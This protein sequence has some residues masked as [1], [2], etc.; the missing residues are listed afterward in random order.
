MATSDTLLTDDVGASDD[1][2]TEEL[3]SPPPDPGT[4][5]DTSE[6]SPPD[7]SSVKP[8]TDD[9]SEDKES[10]GDES[11]EKES[12]DDDTE[13]VYEDF[14]MPEGVE[15]D[16]G[17]LD[18]AV[19]LFKNLKLTQEQAQEL[20]D[21]QAESVQKAVHDQISSFEKTIDDWKTQSLS[22]K[23]YGGEDFEKNLAAAQSA[24]AT[25]GTPELKKF[26]N[27][28]GA[29][30]NPEVIRF[31]WKIGQRLLQDNPTDVG[32]SGVGEQD[33]VSILYPNN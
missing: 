23:E 29:G 10:T 26:L 24:I 17:L 33:R 28:T 14:V 8:S 22:D 31:A 3:G 18:K 13:Q 11:E 27:D 16:K 4:S 19:P 25:F 7:D 21:L 12:S 15:V 20:V 32:N 2:S 5:D 30:S 6:D 9:E 1:T